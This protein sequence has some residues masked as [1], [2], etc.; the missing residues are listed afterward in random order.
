MGVHYVNGDLV[1]DGWLDAARPEALLYEY[2]NGEPQLAGVEYVVIADAWNAQSAAPPVLMG[3]LFNFVGSP[4]HYGLPAFY[5]LHVWAWKQNPRGFFA[6]F[7]P[8]V[9]G[10]SFAADP[11]QHALSH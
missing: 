8:T 1:G 7:N 2:K 6:D 4:N 9:A 11:A 3:Q 10:E 5:A